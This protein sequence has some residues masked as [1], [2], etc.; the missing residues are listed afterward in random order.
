MEILGMS[1]LL[2]IVVRYKDD[3]DNKSNVFCYINQTSGQVVVADPV[4]DKEILQ[5][6]IAEFIKSKQKRPV[7]PPV[8]KDGFEKIDPK[9]YIDS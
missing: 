1:V 3:A 7:I 5:T 4:S 6:M 2:P 9:N 8:P